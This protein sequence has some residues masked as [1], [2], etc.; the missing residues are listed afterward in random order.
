[1][2]VSIFIYF[3]LFI[4]ITSRADAQGTVIKFKVTLNIIK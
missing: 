3:Y 1:L 2:Y 4:L